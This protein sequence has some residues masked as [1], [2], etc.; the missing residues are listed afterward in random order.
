MEFG[1]SEEQ[2]FLRDTLTRLLAEQAGLARARRFVDGGEQRAADLWEGLKSLGV[3]GLIID[4][5][6]GG[7]GLT[8]LDA[9]TVAQTLGAAIAPVPFI[10]TT[11]LAPR[12]IARAGTAAQ[13]SQWLPRIAA[14]DAIVGAALSESANG[15]REGAGVTAKSGTLSGKALFV[16]DFEADAYVVADAQRRL[17]LVDAAAA[18]LTRKRLTTI[19]GTRPIGELNFAGVRADA[20]PGSEDTAVLDDLLGV[21][22]VM[23]AADTL[24]AAQQMLAQA[25]AYSLERKQF[26]RPIGSFQAVKHMCA[27]MAADLEPCQALVWYAAHALD[28]LPEEASLTACHAKAHVA[29]VGKFVA[30]TATEVHGGMGFTDLLGLHYWFKRIGLNRQLL[31]GPERLRTEAA[32]LQGLVA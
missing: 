24:G 30:K 18:G 6:H 2:E 20:L 14:G 10:A 16:L 9:A 31:G 7:V 17:H 13:K 25:V 26:E 3:P 22:R 28:A 5:A 12:A 1:L 32:R 27:E 21:G 11:V 23:L 29:E 4:E 15:A 19:D 8:A